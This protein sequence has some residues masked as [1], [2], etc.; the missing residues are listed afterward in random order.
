VIS[1]GQAPTR[2]SDQDNQNLKIGD[3]AELEKLDRCV[4]I[5][6]RLTFCFSFELDMLLARL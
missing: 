2:T 5:S 6:P 1:P 3:D 4:Q